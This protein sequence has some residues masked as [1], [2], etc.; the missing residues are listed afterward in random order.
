MA[1]AGA[2]IGP[3]LSEGE[4]RAWE[5]GA[6]LKLPP[7]LRDFLAAQNGSLPDGPMGLSGRD[8]DLEFFMPLVPAPRT[9][10]PGVEWDAAMIWFA[11]DSLGGRYGIAHRGPGFGRVFHEGQEVA[12]SFA[13]FLAALAAR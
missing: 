13:A 12:E 7:A 8:E 4:I 2:P 6:R 5:A 10:V 11:R 9:G 1:F 3:K